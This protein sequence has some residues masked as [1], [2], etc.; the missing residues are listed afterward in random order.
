[1]GLFAGIFQYGMNGFCYLLAF[2][3]YFQKPDYFRLSLLLILAFFLNPPYTGAVVSF[4]TTGLLLNIDRGQKHKR[5]IKHWQTFYIYYP[6][7]LLLLC[8]VGYLILLN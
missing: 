4:I 7:H 1:M 3:F 6:A 8:A 5:L 2:Y